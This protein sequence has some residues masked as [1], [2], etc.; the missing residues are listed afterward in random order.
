LIERLCVIVMASYPSKPQLVSKYAVPA[1]FAL[2]PDARGEVKAAAQ[3]LLATLAS[4]MG[5]ALL[6]TASNLSPANQQKLI[7]LLSPGGSSRRFSREV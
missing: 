1:A 5:P 3:Q 6:E 7:E 4:L 2:L